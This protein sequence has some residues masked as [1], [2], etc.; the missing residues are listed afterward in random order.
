MLAKQKDG[1]QRIIELRRGGKLPDD[2]KT[3]A[4][5]L[6]L[7]HQDRQIRD[8]AAKVLPMPRIADGRV[9]P[10]VGQLLS[11]HGDP[12]R[13]RAV[14]FRTGQTACASCHRVQ[15]Q[16]QWI[17]PDLSTIGTK[18]GKDELLR[19]ILDPIV[20]IGTAFARRFWGW[21][22]DERSP[23]WSWRRRQIGWS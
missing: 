3:E 13:G 19:S 22:T 4:V 2:L 6:L 15:G 5:M 8:Q 14:F 12:D 20:A 21:R 7:T 10:P 18:Y 9:L 11:R 1:G 17:G 16:G 23:G